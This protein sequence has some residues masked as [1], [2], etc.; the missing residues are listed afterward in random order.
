MFGHLGV[1]PA[2]PCPPPP[3]GAAVQVE[4][5]LGITASVLGAIDGSFVSALGGVLLLADGDVSGT[6]SAGDDRVGSADRPFSRR[7][8]ADPPES[9]P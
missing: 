8:L 5:G 4:R 1:S 6:V 9:E 2:P 3:G 7:A